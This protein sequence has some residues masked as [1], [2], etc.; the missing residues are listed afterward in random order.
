LNAAT[1]D[2]YLI[3]SGFVETSYATEQR[4]FAATAGTDNA[5]EFAFSDFQVKAI[6]KGELPALKG[7][8]HAGDLK[9]RR[10]HALC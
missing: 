7:L 8:A 9:T 3:V 5:Q 6:E 2:R 1:I 10:R 4:A